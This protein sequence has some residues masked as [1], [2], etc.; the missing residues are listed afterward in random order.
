MSSQGA[1][2]Q[3]CVSGSVVSRLCRTG[4]GRCAGRRSTCTG[5]PRADVAAFFR[6]NSAVWEMPVRL[7]IDLKKMS[8]E[9]AA[10]MWPEHESA[11]VAVA[12]MTAPAQESW[13][14]GKQQGGDVGLAFNP[15]NGLAAHRPLGAIMRSRR[16]AYAASRPFRKRN[17]VAIVEP[18]LAEALPG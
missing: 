16:L 5:G 3:G 9:D 12:R 10:T 18:A 2:L 8:V 17:G 1:Q 14:T 4:C 11:Y 13:S 7:C 6:G 15:W